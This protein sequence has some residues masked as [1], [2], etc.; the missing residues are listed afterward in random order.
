LRPPHPGFQNPSG[1]PKLKI[2]INIPTPW[3]PKKGKVRMKTNVI[4]QQNHATYNKRTIHQHE[5][6]CFSKPA[7]KSHMQKVLSSIPAKVS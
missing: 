7:R 2:K 1:K 4:T 3:H 5:N 6:P